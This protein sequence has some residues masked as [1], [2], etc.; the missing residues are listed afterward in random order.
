MCPADDSHLTLEF[1]EHYLLRPTIRF[2]WPQGDYVVDALG[3][4]GRP[5]EQGFEYN[6]G[7]NPRF[8][9]VEEIRQF[10]QAAGE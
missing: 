9:N 10:N 1:S 6:S 3:Q 2:H 7:T 4:K 5:V 8:L